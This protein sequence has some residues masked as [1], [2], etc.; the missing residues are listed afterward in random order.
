MIV[1]KILENAKYAYGY[2]AQTNAYGDLVAA[3]VIDPTKVVRSALQA[4]W[5]AWRF[6]S[7]PRK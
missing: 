5:G 1:G 3:G 7:R 2:N 6:R 4:R